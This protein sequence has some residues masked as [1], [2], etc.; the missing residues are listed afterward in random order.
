MLGPQHSSHQHLRFY[1]VMTTLIIGGIFLFLLMN[2]N[3]TGFSLTSALI[4][5]TSREADT[6]ETDISEESII[7]ENELEETV[8]KTAKDGSHKIDLSLDFNQIPSVKKEAKFEE[9]ELRFDNLDTKINVN[10]DKLELN[11]LQEVNLKVKNFVGKLNFN[12]NGVSLDGTAK[13]IEVNDI[14]LSSY[15]EIKISFD[16]LN[17]EFLNI[18]DIELKE[19]ELSRGDGH[20]EVGDKLSYSLSNEEVSVYSYKG[21]FT[22]DRNADTS[23]EVDGSAKGVSVNGDLMSLGLN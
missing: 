6:E 5:D 14:A 21:G 12:G 16:D 11:N 19:L 15:G 3:E 4:S 1:V 22:I 18:K 8:S 20:L 23:L 9:I 7:P 17:Y 2:N 10:N 13:R